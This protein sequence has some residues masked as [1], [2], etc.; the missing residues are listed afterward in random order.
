MAAWWQH[1]KH[2]QLLVHNRISGG[3]G[4]QENDSE[5]IILK[6]STDS[7]L[8]ATATDVALTRSDCRMS[9]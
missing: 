2:R 7:V 8:M 3:T 6:D 9:P 5:A 1:R 4:A